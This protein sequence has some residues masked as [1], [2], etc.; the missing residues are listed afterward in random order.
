MDAEFWLYLTCILIALGV[1][2]LGAFLF[3]F[4]LRQRCTRL[5]WALGDLQ[6]RASSFKGKEL[7]EKRWS[8]EKAFDAE[9]AAVLQGAPTVTRRKYD[10]D[11]LGE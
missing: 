4:S 2:L 11:P 3:Q 6:Q 10:N 8:K 9:V 5:E 1:S 7:A